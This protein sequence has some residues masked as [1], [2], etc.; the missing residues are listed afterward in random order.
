MVP[1]S[2]GQDALRLPPSI[3]DQAAG[4]VAS[5]GKLNPWGIDALK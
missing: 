1:G 5:I 3:W 2:P 4:Q